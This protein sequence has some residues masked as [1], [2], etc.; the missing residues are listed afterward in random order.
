MVREHDCRKAAAQ[1]TDEPNL[2]GPQQVL[3]ARADHRKAP[4]RRVATKRSAPEPTVT[5]QTR[6]AT[7]M[8][9]ITRMRS[10]ANRTRAR[11]GA[12]DPVLDYG[13]VIQVTVEGAET[14]L[15]RQR[16]PRKA[17]KRPFIRMEPLVSVDSK[18]SAA[19]RP[20]LATW[21]GSASR[22]RVS[23]LSIEPAGCTPLVGRRPR[24]RVQTT[25]AGDLAPQLERP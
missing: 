23:V 21:S 25:G 9:A 3:C 12:Q 4:T 19:A 18:S 15:P 10:M 17:D 24:R 8:C 1:R 20:R 14:R 7:A 16:V 13:H 2:K 5:R 11:R 6:W 22:S